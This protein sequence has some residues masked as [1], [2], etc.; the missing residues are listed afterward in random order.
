MPIYLEDL[1]VAVKLLQLGY[2]VGQLIVLI[3]RTIFVVPVMG[4]YML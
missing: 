4:V 2:F 3:S 1:G